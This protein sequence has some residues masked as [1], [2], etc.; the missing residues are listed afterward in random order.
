MRLPFSTM[1]LWVFVVSGWFVKTGSHAFFP[2]FMVRYFMD[3]GYQK[4]I[5]IKAIIDG[6]H[7]RATLNRGAVIPKLCDTA[8]RDP[9]MNIAFSQPLKYKFDR[10]RRNM[11]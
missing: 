4:V 5:W 1:G 3:Q 9:E 7:C 11:G 8:S 6:N 2:N 10:F